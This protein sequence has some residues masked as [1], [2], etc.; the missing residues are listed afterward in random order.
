MSVVRHKEERWRAVVVAWDRVGTTS[1]KTPTTSLT[2]KDYTG[3]ADK[4]LDAS[5]SEKEDKVQYTLI[6]DFGDAHL[7]GG[8]PRTNNGQTTLPV[9]F[10]Y[11]L[12]PVLDKRYNTHKTSFLLCSSMTIGFFSNTVETHS[13]M[14]IIDLYLCHVC[15]CV[16]PYSTSHRVG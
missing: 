2:K 1:T 8:S 15:V 13:P 10:G 6:L 9:A 3:G 4:E 16:L 7:L 11:D 14:T 12:E 5:S